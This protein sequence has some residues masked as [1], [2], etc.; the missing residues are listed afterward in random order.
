MHG[1]KMLAKPAVHKLNGLPSMSHSYS[2][3]ECWLFLPQQDNLARQ[4]G[5]CRLLQRRMM[6][7]SVQLH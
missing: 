1:W 6:A 7:A 3:L 4:S 2:A 5:W